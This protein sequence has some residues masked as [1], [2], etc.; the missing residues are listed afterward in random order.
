LI[1]VFPRECESAAILK[2]HRNRAIG[3]AV[4]RASKAASR[5]GA[6]RVERSLRRNSRA[7]FVRA[8]CDACQH[9]FLIAFSCKGRGVCAACNA[10]RM[11]ETAAHLADHVMPRLPVSQWALSVPKRLRYYLRSDPALQTLVP[12]VPAPSRWSSAPWR[13]IA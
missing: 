12:G 8:F 13:R 10:R 1:G 9:N 11:V 6:Y 7:A 3:A 4:E 2:A 5:L